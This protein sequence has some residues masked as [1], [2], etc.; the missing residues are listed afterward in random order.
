MDTGRFEE[1]LDEVFAGLG[2]GERLILGVSDNVPPDAD[3]DRLERIGARVEAFGPV[4]PTVTAPR[5][6]GGR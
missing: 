2:T 4:R 5:G 6:A 1:Y 3:L